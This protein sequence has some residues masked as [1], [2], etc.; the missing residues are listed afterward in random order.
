MP[1]SDGKNYATDAANTETIFRI[2]QAIPSPRA[3]PEFKQWLARVGF[4]RIREHQ[5]PSIAIKRAICDYQLQGRSID[6]IEARLR[7]IFCTQGLP[8][9]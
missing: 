7:T 5:N 3:E 1:S 9:A 8:D 2:I 6:W 4:E